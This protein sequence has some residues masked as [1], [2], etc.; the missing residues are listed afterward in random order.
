MSINDVS[1]SSDAQIN[2]ETFDSNAQL[3]ND[4]DPIHLLFSSLPKWVIATLIDA[5]VFLQVFPHSG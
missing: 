1:P 5:T 2:D 4:N 3:S